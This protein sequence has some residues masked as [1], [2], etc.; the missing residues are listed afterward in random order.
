M[1]IVSPNEN[2]S[3]ATSLGLLI[4]NEGKNHTTLKPDFQPN[5][6]IKYAFDLS[7]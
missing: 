3:I 4:L 1:S 5:L 7:F 6:A 2:L